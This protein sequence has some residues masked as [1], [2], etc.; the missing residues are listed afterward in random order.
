VVLTKLLN[1]RWWW[2]TIL[3]IAGVLFLIRLGFWQLDR[4]DQR[5]AFNATVAERWQETPYDLV[6]DGP[7]ANP[8]DLEYRRVEVGGDFDY[9]NQ[10]VLKERPRDGAPGVIMVTPLLLD[11]GRAVLVARGWVPY[12][13]SAPEHWPE[14]EER[15]DGSVIGLIQESQLSPSGEAPAAPEEA[16]TEWFLLNID[17]IQPQM[18]YELLPFFIL[19]L[20]EDG[21]SPM[22]YPVRDEPLALDEGSHFSY[23]IQWFMFS[24]ILGIGYL[25]L[26][27]QQEQRSHRLA[28]E[29]ATVAGDQ[30]GGDVHEVDDQSAAD[31]ESDPSM[32]SLP[33][34]H[35]H[36]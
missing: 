7:P 8:A 1:R 14:L 36:A 3:V 32:P 34:Q 15:S 10:I 24:A 31:P 13:L 21:R 5:R 20:P 27:Q 29:D 6:S 12:N 2:K 16:Q 17:A 26:I 33:T 30:P 25:F 9:R 19:Q 35:G 4:L 23:A 22:Q 28:E 18:P 11:D